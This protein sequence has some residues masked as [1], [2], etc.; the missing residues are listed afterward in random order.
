MNKIFVDTDVI[1]DLLARRIPHFHFSA[2]LFTF[3]EMKKLELYTTPLIIANTFYILRKQL[4]NESAKNVLRKLRILL[5]IIDSTESII[6]KALNSDF[7]DFEDAIQYYT[8]LEYGI[9]VILTRNIRDYKKA[10]I[11]VQTPESYLVTRKLI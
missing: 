9:P 7:S 2:V 10:S 3:A 1:L 11:V 6:D 5:H 8:A 4:G